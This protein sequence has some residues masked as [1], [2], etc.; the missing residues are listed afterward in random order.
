VIAWALGA[1]SAV[2]FVVDPIAVV[3]IFLAITPGD[4][5]A[6]RAGMARTASIVAAIVLMGFTLG[7][8]ALFHLFG[9]T[10]PA[11]EIAG[12]VLLLLTAIEQLRSSPPA[13]RTS[14]PEIAAGSARDD[15]AIVPLALPLLA[16]PGSIATV[17]VLAGEA[18]SW[19][20]TLAILA[21]ILVT[22]A[23]GWALL[24]AAGAVDRALGASGKAVLLRITGLLLAAIAVQFILGGLLETF[25]GLARA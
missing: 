9:V 21:S 22:C 19:M 1:F 8:R 17:M 24:S 23:I 4:G 18:S 6:R 16:G 13:T 2:F 14:G 7:G 3:P 12:G 10:L 25:P 11:F 5:D 20:Q 15:V